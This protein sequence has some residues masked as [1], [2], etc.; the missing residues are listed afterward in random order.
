MTWVLALIVKPLAAALFFCGVY[1]LAWV[2]WKILPPGPLKTALF[3]PVGG[4]KPT[5]NTHWSRKV[6]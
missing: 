4:K 6:E 1:W 3:S 5:R 2:F